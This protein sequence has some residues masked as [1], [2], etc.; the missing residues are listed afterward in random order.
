MRPALKMWP[1]LLSW[2][3]NLRVHT[4]THTHTSV[5]I[6]HVTSFILSTFETPLDLIWMLAVGGVTSLW[7]ASLILFAVLFSYP[8][9]H[10]LLSLMPP[11][12]F[13]WGAEG[14]QGLWRQ[15]LCKLLIMDSLLWSQMMYRYRIGCPSQQYE[16]SIVKYKI[17]IIILFSIETA[18]KH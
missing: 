17:I 9:L 13:V 15:I 6:I 8:S 11:V 3:R 7:A 5:F 10:L 18:S 1:C 12:R 14:W 2:Q 4:H 16:S